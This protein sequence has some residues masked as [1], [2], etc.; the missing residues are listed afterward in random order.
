MEEQ[1]HVDGPLA[2]ALHLDEPLGNLLVRDLLDVV[3]P[4]RAGLEPLRE[5]AQEHDLRAREPGRGAEL[6]GIVGEDLRRG[7]RPAAVAVGQAPV[8]ASRRRDRELLPDD[9]PQQGAVVIVRRAA[10]VRARTEHAGPDA[11][12]DLGHHGIGGAEVLDGLLVVGI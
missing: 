7:G 4:E 2:D 8:D 10:A 3:E 12:D 1:V 6:L 9:R 5:V 11:L